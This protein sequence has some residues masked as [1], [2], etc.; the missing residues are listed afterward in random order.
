[1]I[2][3]WPL[4]DLSF[5]SSP[6]SKSDRTVLPALLLRLWQVACISAL[7]RAT[8]VLSILKVSESLVS[9]WVSPVS[10]RIAYCSSPSNRMPRHER[11]SSG[12]LEH[13]FNNPTSYD[14]RNTTR[15]TTVHTTDQQ[16]K[17]IHHQ[18]QPPYLDSLP[19]LTLHLIQYLP[20]RNSPTFPR[21]QPQH[22]AR[23]P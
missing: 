4:S 14:R 15:S 8:V 7:Q 13:T 2:R 9:T 12:R 18:R 3:W 1:M 10:L 23:Q 11:T 16:S 20:E 21:L 6:A 19:T 22:L 5:E 17:P